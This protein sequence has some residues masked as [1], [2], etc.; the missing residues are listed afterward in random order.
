M[1]GFRGFAACKDSLTVHLQSAKICLRESNDCRGLVS[2]LVDLFIM[3]LRFCGAFFSSLLSSFL[4]TWSQIALIY[5]MVL[6]MPITFSLLTYGLTD[7]HTF[8]FIIVFFFT[9]TNTNIQYIHAF[10]IDTI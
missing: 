6:L 7:I 1:F 4:L 9:A 8:F 10:H 5:Y 2:S 3:I